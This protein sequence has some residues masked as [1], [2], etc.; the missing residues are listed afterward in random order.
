MYGF[1]RIEHALLALSFIMLA[2][3]G[4]AL[5]YPGQWWARLLSRISE[6]KNLW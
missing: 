5:K 6:N 4:F 2:W 3:T 1:E